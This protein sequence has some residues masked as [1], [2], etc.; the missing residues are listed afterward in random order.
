MGKSFHP[1]G[2]GG[3]DRQSGAGRTLPPSAGY[4]GGCDRI[5]LLYLEHHPGPA[6]GRKDKGVEAGNDCG[7]GRPGGRLSGGGTADRL[8][9]GGLYPGRRGGIPFRAADEPSVRGRGACRCAGAVPAAAGGRRCDTASL[10]FTGSAALPLHR[11]L[12][13]RPAGADRLSGNLPG[14]SLFLRLLSFRTGGSG[15]LF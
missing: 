10:P 14:L 9:G 8:A 2:G 15:S 6:V 3:G 5:L 7:A 11:L 4:P 12:L 13:R 1:G